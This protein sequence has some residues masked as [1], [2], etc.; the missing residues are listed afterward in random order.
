MRFSAIVAGVF[1]IVAIL[2][3]QSYGD[4]LYTFTD[5]GDPGVGIP[6][7]SWEYDA[8]QFVTTDTFLTQ[9]DLLSFSSNVLEVD[10]LPS[11]PNFAG[12]NCDEVRTEFTNTNVGQDFATGTFQT[13][14]TYNVG[15]GAT[16]TVG[17]VPAP[18]IGHGLLAVLAV[19]GLLFGADLWARSKRRRS[20]GTDTPRAAA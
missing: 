8:P 7:Y 19:G 16:L 13:P 15:L 11:C 3:A 2:S 12:N 18:L 1:A 6:A 10:L 5:T 9:G 14:G 17:A 4:V 20:F